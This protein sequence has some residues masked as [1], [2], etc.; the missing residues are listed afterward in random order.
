MRNQVHIISQN[1]I[2]NRNDENEHNMSDTQNT[3]RESD[4]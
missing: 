3:Q 2:F 1:E 4:V